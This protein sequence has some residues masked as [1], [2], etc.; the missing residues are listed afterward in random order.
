MFTDVELKYLEDQLVG[1]LATVQP[2]G[3]VQVNPVSFRYNP[4]L[5]TIDIGGFSFAASRK[6]RNV[7]DNG[8]AALVVDDVVSTDPWRIRC[9]EIRGVAETAIDPAAYPELDDEI[10]RIHPKRIIS[11]GVDEPDVPP[12]EL[13][14]FN[15][16]VG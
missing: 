7:A 10:I 12:H 16:N 2:G 11:F 15:R 8:K 3:N 14:Y 9:V 6:F 4:A 13:T 5:G 1:R